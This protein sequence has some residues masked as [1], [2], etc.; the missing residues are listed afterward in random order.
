MD[1]PNSSQG[2]PC[3]NTAQI[4]D[5][6]KNIFLFIKNTFQKFQY[7]S[8]LVL[9]LVLV[10]VT[11]HLMSNWQREMESAPKKATALF[12]VAGYM[13][14]E[15]LLSELTTLKWRHNWKSLHI[16]VI[17][18]PPKTWARNAICFQIVW[19]KS[20]LQDFHQSH[21]FSKISRKM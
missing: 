19:I 13:K 15:E 16:Y 17:D 8:V 3:Q 10:L 4:K 11:W 5:I 12:S 6:L 20:P 7:K 18:L 14:T 2:H 1:H 21:K 9:V